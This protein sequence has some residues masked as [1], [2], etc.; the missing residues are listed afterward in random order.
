M[1]GAMDRLEVLLLLEPSSSFLPTAVPTNRGSLR[2]RWLS[3][4]DPH[5]TGLANQDDCARMVRSKQDGTT[6]GAIQVR[7]DSNRT[8][9]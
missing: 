7:P 3:T 8:K 5:P 9:H 6:L 2:L 1:A 4:L